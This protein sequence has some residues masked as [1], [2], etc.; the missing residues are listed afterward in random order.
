METQI[1]NSKNENIC[2][3]LDFPDIPHKNK[4]AFICHGITGYK[5]QDVILQTVSSL[6][7]QGYTI[8]SFDCRNSRG[9][10]FNNHQ[11]ATL[12]DFCDDLKTVIDWTKNQSF[13]IN[14]F[15]LAGHSLGV[16]TILDY[17]TNHP[18]LIKAIIAISGVFSGQDLLK[19]TQKFAPEF[20]NSLQ[21]GGII[22][23][24]ENVECYLDFSYLEDAQKYDFYPN[25]EK[26]NKPI[27]L[28]TGDKDI[29]STPQNNQAFFNQI[30]GNKELHIL[31][32][33]SHIYEKKDNQND[34]NDIISGFISTKVR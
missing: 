26:F 1:K 2:I 32:N 5:E 30:K 23:S 18:N 12:T 20:L 3:K 15:I 25:I 24:N 34:L 22:R 14:S 6:K 28:I 9:K 17:A 31:K 16:A 10:S 11:C 33:C 21:N 27:L 4:L 13:Y 7:S 8:V 29:A 19:N